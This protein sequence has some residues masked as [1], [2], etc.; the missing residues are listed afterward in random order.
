MKFKIISLVAFILIVVSSILPLKFY[1]F[2]YKKLKTIEK[3]NNT[4]DRALFKVL[5]KRLK[6]EAK[7]NRCKNYI[8]PI[9]E[10]SGFVS[11][12]YPNLK[13]D[14]NLVLRTYD[15]WKLRVDK[16]IQKEMNRRIDKKF[17]IW[18]DMNIVQEVSNIIDRQQKTD[19]KT[20]YSVEAKCININKIEKGK[21]KIVLS[22]NNDIS[23]SNVFKVSATFLKKSIVDSL[24]K[25][26]EQA[27]T[28]IFVL[29]FFLFLYFIYFIIFSFLSLRKIKKA[30]EYEKYLLSEIQ[31]REDL[32]RNGHFVLALE[33]CDKYLK[34][35]P[36]DTDIKAFRQR[37]LDFTNNDPQKSQLAYVENK[38][39]ELKIASG[40]LLESEEKEKIKE[41]LPYNENLATAFKQYEAVSLKMIEDKNSEAE[42]IFFESKEDLK[43][44]KI[45]QAKE[46]LESI[47]FYEKAKTLLESFNPLKKTDKLTLSSENGK[48]SYLYFKNEIMIGRSDEDFQIDIDLEDKR[49][50]RNHLK[51]SVKGS[52]IFAEDLNSTG[53]TFLDGE[54]I[55]KTKIK[56]GNTLTI[57]RVIDCTFF[58]IGA[59]DAI[60]SFMLKI[61]DENHIIILREAKITLKDF[62]LCLEEGESNLFLKDG[63]VIFTNGDNIYI[64]NNNMQIQIDSNTYN[65]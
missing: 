4:Y 18:K 22:I 21:I 40:S 30:K 31:K 44:G 54:K 7:R 58:F 32:I 2:E 1:V 13:T 55:T 64:L 49:A 62:S 50:S 43:Q 14:L 8:L 20:K 57:A 59:G 63:Y 61:K 3:E 23:N 11:S 34:I 19:F 51:I 53:G 6:D 45:K 26:E 46:M 38:K 56:S 33:L 24:Y 12:E 27:K 47:K 60:K 37:I 25:K 36:E 16:K 52:E 9:S 10:V 29:C 65:I 28:S 17:I 35:F 48:K 41:L 5:S 39:L 15:K 42:A